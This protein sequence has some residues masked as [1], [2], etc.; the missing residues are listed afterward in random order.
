MIL[1][2]V[3]PPV[4]GARVWSEDRDAK[5]I[6]NAMASV[7]NDVDTYPGARALSPNKELVEAD[8]IPK[9]ATPLSMYVPM[10]FGCVKSYALKNSTLDSFCS[11][12]Q[13]STSGT[14]PS[15]WLWVAPTS[16]RRWL[17]SMK[18]PSVRVLTSST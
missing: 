16:A 15:R 14:H 18:F 13:N 4:L 1:T 12:V 9:N 6:N 3:A 2:L 17:L 10:K 7:Q 5:V 8:P 11:Y